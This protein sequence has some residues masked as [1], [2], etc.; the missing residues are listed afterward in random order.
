[1]HRSGTSSVAQALK[2]LGLYLG[3]GQELHHLTS[4]LEGRQM[5]GSQTLNIGSRIVVLQVGQEALD[6]RDMTFVGCH[7]QWFTVTVQRFIYFVLYLQLRHLLVVLPCHLDPN[8][9]RVMC[10]NVSMHTSV[11]R[12]L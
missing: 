6:N 3:D 9:T 7:M 8:T 5:K 4:A 10:T 11:P 2:H 12:V 1:M